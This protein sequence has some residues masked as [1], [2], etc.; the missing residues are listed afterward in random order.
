MEKIKR[1]LYCGWRVYNMNNANTFEDI[2]K[3]IDDLKVMEANKELDIVKRQ[4][5]I[6]AVS[7]YT[8]LYEDAQKGKFNADDLHENISSFM[9]MFQ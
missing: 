6:K 3:Y 8:K 4:H 5:I 1:K 2:K 9:Y 7:T